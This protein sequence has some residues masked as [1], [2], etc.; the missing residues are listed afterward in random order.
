[1]KSAYE[2]A[3]DRLN[4]T[5]PARKLTADQKARIA[6]LD[7]VFKAKTA[8][9]ELAM[10]DAVAKAVAAGD[11]A[12]LETARQRFQ[13]DRAKFVADLEARKEAVRNEG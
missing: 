7:S 4:R 3:M 13:S 12:A 2:L 5:A 1:M 11:E 9:A 6:E 10:N 8:E